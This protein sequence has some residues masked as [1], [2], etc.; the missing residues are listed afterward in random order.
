MLCVPY[1]TVHKYL[2]NQTPV[3]RG[4]C[5]ILKVRVIYIRVI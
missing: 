2:P 4:M 5:T 1:L 3:R